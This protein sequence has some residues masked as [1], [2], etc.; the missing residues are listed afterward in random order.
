MSLAM[1][2][3]VFIAGGLGGAMALYFAWPDVAKRSEDDH[4]EAN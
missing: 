3:A 1:W 4:K 2:S